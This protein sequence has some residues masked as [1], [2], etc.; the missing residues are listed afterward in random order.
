MNPSSPP[1]HSQFSFPFEEGRR[2]SG[3]AI[4]PGPRLVPRARPQAWPTPEPRGTGRLGLAAVRKEAVPGA[5]GLEAAA[6]VGPSWVLCAQGKGRNDIVRPGSRGRGVVGQGRSRGSK[7]GIYG[8]VLAK[9][10]LE[11][12]LQPL[13]RPADSGHLHGCAGL[14][15]P[16]ALC[17]LVGARPGQS[18]RSCRC[19]H[20]RRPPLPAPRRP[21]PPSARWAPPPALPQLWHPWRGPRLAPPSRV[22]G[23]RMTRGVHQ[24]VG[25]RAPGGPKG[26]G[27]A[28][29]RAAFREP[30]GKK[31]LFLPMQ[32][33]K[34]GPQGSPACP[35]PAQIP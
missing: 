26:G 13:A 17:A 27:S 14:R 34:P 32:T 9:E 2:G 18:R 16:H 33:P 24:L 30:L 1:P 11:S 7:F 28:G 19:R 12:P 8:A 5:A 3:R 29:N 25:R 15:G 21:A 4:V 6:F 20:R 35:C 22:T 10:A 23:Q 31:V